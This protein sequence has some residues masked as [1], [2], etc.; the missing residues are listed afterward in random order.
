MTGEEERGSG[1]FKQAI[2]DNIGTFE[3]R[4]TSHHITSHHI[5]S[6]HITS[7][8]SHHIIHITS[9]HITSHHITS[10]HITSHHITSH[11]FTSHHITS[12]HIA[13]ASAILVSNNYWIDDVRPCLTI[14]M[15]GA[16]NCE[17]SVS[18]PRW[19]WQRGIIVILNTC[20]CVIKQ[21]QSALGR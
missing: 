13:G 16:I 4:F 12:H 8:I 2:K 15:R 7:S 5:T 3:G 6:H 20:H 14:G 18:G 1:G 9:H 17:L 11:Y 10:H 19:E 21:H